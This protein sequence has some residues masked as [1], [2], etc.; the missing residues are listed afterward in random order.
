M[1]ERLKELLKDYEY[2][3]ENR[4]YLCWN[5]KPTSQFKLFSGNKVHNTIGL[6]NDAINKENDDKPLSQLT[7]DKVLQLSKFCI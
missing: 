3:K 4:E 1:D 6:I 5:P 2:W 7:V